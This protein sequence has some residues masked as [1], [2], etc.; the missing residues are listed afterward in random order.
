M[1]RRQLLIILLGLF[2]ISGYGQHNEEVTI[3]GAYRPQVNKVN[4]MLMKPELPEPSFTMPGT[5]VHP[6]EIDHHF[7][8][9]LEKIAPLALNTKDGPGQGQITENFLMA[10]IGTRLSPVFF[11]KHHS[12][13]TKELALGVGVNH[14]SSWLGIEDYGPSAFMNNAF[15]ISLAS[16][17]YKNI[18]LGG[19]VYYKNDMV[20]F[21]GFHP[22][23]TDVS[24]LADLTRQT[25]NTIGMHVG[26]A[27][28]T[29][30]LGELAHSGDLDYHYLFDRYDGREHYVGLNYELGYSESWW[31]SKSHPQKAGVKLSFEY[32]HYQGCLVESQ[33]TYDHLNRMLFQVNPYFE[34]KDEFYRLRLGFLADVVNTRPMFGIY[35]DLKGSL[36]VLNKKVEFY[37]GLNGGKKLVTYSQL[38]EENPFLGREVTEIAPPTVKLGFEGGVRTNI[39]ETVDVHLGV[40]YRNTKDDLF[41]VPATGFSSVDPLVGLHTFGTVTSDTRLVSLLANVRWLAL[42][43]LSV[44]AGFAYNQYRMSNLAHPLY[45]PAM[46]GDLKLRYDFNENLSLNASLLYLGGR[47]GGLTGAQAQK[48]KDVFDLG[49]GA[50][51][52]LHD[53]LA[54]FVKIDNLAHQKYQ[55][56]YDYPV[57]GIQLFAGVKM[58]F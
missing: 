48:L 37:A 47:Y 5:E 16:N 14:Y 17:R 6:M 52:K 28:A 12:K 18:Q 43:R 58:R 23:T 56:F 35:P 8:I 51:Y 46:E 32:A 4:K 42:D 21:Y 31:G 15:D 1:Y 40:R 9:D 57:T 10:G 25:Y 38:V 13:L 36:F 45:R 33:H 39:M 34:M 49:L 20:H 44:D 29:T 7:A 30:R 3:E 54:V 2:G 26:A 50:D 24:S 27:S 55:V 11:Y 53:Q 41:F 22:N 19:N